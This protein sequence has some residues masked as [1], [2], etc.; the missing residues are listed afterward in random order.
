MVKKGGYNV[1]G[2][3]ILLPKNDPHIKTW[4]SKLWMFG[5]HFP[6]QG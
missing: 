4:W 6:L 1:F 3:T 2:S 5:G